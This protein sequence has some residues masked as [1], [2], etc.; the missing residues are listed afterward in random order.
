M[1]EDSTRTIKFMCKFSQVVLRRVVQ[2]TQA[3]FNICGRHLFNWIWSPIV[4]GELD[5]L[6]ERW[7][8]HVICCQRN[9][10]MP[11][12]VSPN[13]LYAHPEHYGGHCFAIQVPQAAI[14]TFRESI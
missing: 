14:N 3:L 10:L 13:E 5:H 6:T 1:R 7:N 11:S 2:L 9:K 8:S 4:Q 12:G